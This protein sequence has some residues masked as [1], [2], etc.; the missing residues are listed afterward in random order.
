MK[1]SKSELIRDIALQRYEKLF[2][3]AIK[4]IKSNP[5]LSRRYIEILIKISQRTRVRIPRNLKYF[6]CKSCHSLLY[7]GITSRIRLSPRRSSH[8]IVTCLI[9][10]R[11]KRYPIS[12]K[13]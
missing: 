5:S 1:L 2:D 3:L 12:K 6:I 8:I 11:I 9:C 7:P 13:K 10:G 4:N